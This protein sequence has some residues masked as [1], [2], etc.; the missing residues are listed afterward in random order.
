MDSLPRRRSEIGG[1]NPTVECS[2][3]GL[4]NRSIMVVRQCV[5]HQ[6]AFG[7]QEK[8]ELLM[9]FTGVMSI[10]NDFRVIALGFE[11]SILKSPA[12]VIDDTQ[13]PRWQWFYES[14]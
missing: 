8:G 7:F 13:S 1:V 12:H 4:V 6:Q 5:L 11:C 10:A 3:D 9:A 14:V 2:P